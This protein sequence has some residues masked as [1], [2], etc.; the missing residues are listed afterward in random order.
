MLKKSTSAKLLLARPLQH[1]I[2]CFHGDGQ[3]V[4][5]RPTVNQ[6]PRELIYLFRR[7]R[8]TA[9]LYNNNR[10]ILTSNTQTDRH[11]RIQDRAIIVVRFPSV[12]IQPD[13]FDRMS[14]KLDAIQSK[15][16]GRP[17]LSRTQTQKN[18]TGLSWCGDVVTSWPRIKKYACLSLKIRLSLSGWYHYL[19]IISSIL[20]FESNF[21]RVPNNDNVTRGKQEMFRSTETKLQELQQNVRDLYFKR[22]P[23]FF[24][25]NNQFPLKI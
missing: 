9:W 22:Y 12:S 24:S 15:T 10:W 7:R 1:P 6:Q 17:Q 2:N 20:G 18:Q 4:T 13:D 11:N 14:S 25:C 21:I 19:N 8:N 3:K 16:S 23:E 5:Y